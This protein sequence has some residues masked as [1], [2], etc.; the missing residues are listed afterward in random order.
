MPEPRDTDYDRMALGGLKSVWSSNA[1]AGL[2]AYVCLKCGYTELYLAN[3]GELTLDK[4]PNA[5]VLKP[6]SGQ[7]PYR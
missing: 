6:E 4:L 2:E 3:L 7:G 5:R 1:N